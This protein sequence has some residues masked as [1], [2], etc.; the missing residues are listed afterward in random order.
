MSTGAYEMGRRM[1]DEGEVGWSDRGQLDQLEI[2]LAPVMLGAGIR[3]FDRVEPVTVALEPERVV[4]S[5]AVTHVR[6]RVTA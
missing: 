5:P 3:L 6:N 1:F 4:E 2:H